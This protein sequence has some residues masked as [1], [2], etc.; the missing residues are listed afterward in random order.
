MR[1]KLCFM[2]WCMYISEDFAFYLPVLKADF[3][4]RVLIRGLI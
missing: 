1:P 2:S 3:G 4:E